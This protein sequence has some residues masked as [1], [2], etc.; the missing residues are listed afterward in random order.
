[1]MNPFTGKRL[2]RRFRY[3]PGV[4]LSVLLAFLLCTG[5]GNSW[6]E[7]RSAAQQIRSVRADFVQEKHL[8]I[9]TKPLISKGVFYFRMPDSLRWEYTDPVQSILLMHDGETRRYIQSSGVYIEDE[10][11]RLQSMQVVI[12]EIT[13]WLNGRFD[14]NPDFSATLTDDRRIVLTPK[15]DSLAS[16]IRRIELRL[17]ETPGLMESVTIYEGEDSYTRLVF[18]NSVLNPDP[19]DT[20]FRDVE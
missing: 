20:I 14:E 6:E 5:W 1:M 17:S 19:D 2:L 15:E 11:A 7:I 4:T 12:Q 13:R 16:I 8:K 3:R 18:Q 9:L 10:T